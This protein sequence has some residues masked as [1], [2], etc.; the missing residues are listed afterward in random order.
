M[1]L[2]A[3][4][5]IEGI[6]NIFPIPKKYEYQVPEECYKEYGSDL[7]SCSRQ[8]NQGCKGCICLIKVGD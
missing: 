7:D 6:K 2:T 8:E 4:M 3:E 5:L 1:K